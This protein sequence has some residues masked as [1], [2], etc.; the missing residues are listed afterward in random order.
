MIATCNN[1]KTNE[2]ALISK[3]TY[4]F[5]SIL[6]VDILDWNCTIITF[7]T[8][9]YSKPLLFSEIGGNPCNVVSFNLTITV[10]N[11]ITKF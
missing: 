7:W 9:F 3:A 2:H 1:S 11:D 5:K 4:C 8:E 10:A 6:N